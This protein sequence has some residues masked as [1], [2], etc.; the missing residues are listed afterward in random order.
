MQ[1]VSPPSIPGKRRHLVLKTIEPHPPFV[2]LS[3]YPGLQ[4]DGTW[5]I[6][7]ESHLPNYSPVCTFCKWEG[8]RLG[9]TCVAFP[10]GIPLQI[11]VGQDNHGYSYPGDNGFTYAPIRTPEEILAALGKS[12]TIH[13][14]DG[15]QHPRAPAGGT[16]G[17]AGGEWI[18]KYL[19]PDAPAST[20]GSAERLAQ[21]QAHYGGN[22]QAAEIN[23]LEEYCLHAPVER[24]Y[25]LSPYGEIL[26]T[27]D[28]EAMSIMFTPA[29]MSRMVGSVFTHNHP[30]GRSFSNADLVLA[31]SVQLGEMRAIGIDPFTRRPVRYVIAPPL[32]GWSRSWWDAVGYDV[33]RKCDQATSTELRGLILAGKIT[34]VEAS[35]M[36]EHE[37]W[38]KWASLTKAHYRKEDWNIPGWTM[39]K[40]LSL[41]TLLDLLGR[42]DR[43]PARDENEIL[44]PAM[45]KACSVHGVRPPEWL[46]SDP[47]L[48][49]KTAPAPRYV[50]EEV[51]F[52]RAGRRYVP[53]FGFE[54]DPLGKSHR[55]PLSIAAVLESA[56]VM[57]GWEQV[58]V[59]GEPYLSFPDDVLP[60]A[61]EAFGEFLKSVGGKKKAPKTQDWEHSLEG[62]TPDD[63]VTHMRHHE[64]EYRE[65]QK[66]LVQ[67]AP[68]DEE[69]KRKIVQ[70]MKKIALH[71]SNHRMARY[72][73][74]TQTKD[75]PKLILKSYNPR[76]AR[77]RG[78]KWSKTPQSEGSFLAQ[79][80]APK[81][82]DEVWF[83]DGMF[84]DTPRQGTVRM[85]SDIDSKGLSNTRVSIQAGGD[86]KNISLGS[87]FPHKPQKV[88]VTDEYGETKVWESMRGRG[89]AKK[90]GL[91]LV[92]RKSQMALFDEES[93]P[94]AAAGT[95]GKYRGGEWV[96]RREGETKPLPTLNIPPRLSGRE[97]KLTDEYLTAGVAEITPK[98]G[99]FHLRVRPIGST[100]Y[101]KVGAFPTIDHARAQ[102][103]PALGTTAEAA[104]VRAYQDVGERIGGARKEIRG[105]RE[106]FLAYPDLTNLAAL[107][108]QD[109]DA[110]ERVVAKTTLWPKPSPEAMTS[111]GKT[112]G[113]QVLTAVVWS[114]IGPKPS[115]PGPEAR[116][117]YLAG[118][119]ILRDVLEP[120]KTAHEFG[121]AIKGLET[122][123]HA[124]LAYARWFSD[125]KAVAEGRMRYYG[126]TPPEP[127]K[128]TLYQTKLA[129]SMAAIPGVASILH[130]GGKQKNVRGRTLGNWQFHMDI[131]D[132][133]VHGT[134]FT[135]RDRVGSK[136]MY[137]EEQRASMASRALGDLK[138][139]LGIKD[140]P[141]DQT[142]KP[143]A[144]PDEVDEAGRKKKWERSVPS[145]YSRKGGKPI[146]I[147]RPEDYLQRFGLRGVEF[148]NW[149]ENASSKVHVDRCAEAFQDLADII[150]VPSKDVSLNGRLALAFGARG[151][152]SAAAHYE[153]GKRVINLTKLGG[154]GSL[155]HEWGHFLDDILA[156]THP[157]GSPREGNGTYLSQRNYGI[158][159]RSGDPVK[160]AM[161]GVFKLIYNGSGRRINK[162]KPTDV[163]KWGVVDRYIEKHPGNPQAALDDM[164]RIYTV[165]PKVV[166]YLG[167]KTGAEFLETKSDKSAY[168]ERCNAMGD[169]WRRPQ[170]LFARAFETYVLDTAEQ[171]G[172]RNN[173]LVALGKGDFEDGPYPTG[174]EREAITEAMGRLVQA[175]KATNFFEKAL[176][177][178]E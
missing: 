49:V 162:V 161:G 119:S 164:A 102:V 37:V 158:L 118:I 80:K 151:T 51:G 79:G 31:V 177:L 160:Q 153:P 107:E 152:G 101:K 6:D 26:G 113:N 70:A 13:A 20:P 68:E 96:P 178:F 67:C 83:L 30:T 1:A 150:G 17:Y 169:Y 143:A 9:R 25:W 40:S 174:V 141:T 115:A 104:S 62:M 2:D 136:R 156:A 167:S 66:Q 10:K 131:L 81:A 32:Q 90:G 55:H 176:R 8:S 147:R 140:A 56:G 35:F 142:P 63:H 59:N 105:A 92:I 122:E 75:A 109:P 34:P 38:K 22:R 97:K 84:A 123:A 82:G 114:Q 50:T 18:P 87:V 127:P 4:P 73:G 3:R 146:S 138:D 12:H 166:N 86:V 52:T 39:D 42:F 15:P 24:A 120:T 108:R 72:I 98:D 58:T 61:P 76:E 85:T 129:T 65:L 144:K 44:F 128:P 172:R 100:R 78:G 135:A 124:V 110:A 93:H 69:Q 47:S 28:G 36:H 134:D 99:Q 64:A 171:K 170:E 45:L 41:G 71:W 157:T 14:P 111:A 19:K 74:R 149:M 132:D 168:Y 130:L 117:Y 137:T 29:E 5:V 95:K 106:E 145:E 126:Q 57:Q 89:L 163:K 21:W 48:E 112:L 148:G 133:D 43:E 16:G 155:G 23:C 91:R 11:W 125:Q 139:I 7:A 60:P 77:D 121:Q 33:W 175:M 46:V 173:Y 159:L 27:K 88:T 165:G 154:A 116:S 103:L 53:L 54:R 94:R